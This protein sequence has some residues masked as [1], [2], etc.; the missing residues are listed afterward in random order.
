MSREHAQRHEAV[1]H[2]KPQVAKDEVEEKATKF[3]G[4]HPPAVAGA[5]H[6]Q[7]GTSQLA[8]EEDE[9]E[10]ELKQ[11]VGALVASQFGGDY[12]KAFSHFDSD[13]DGSVTK[14]ELVQ[15]LEEAG[16]GNGITR[17]MWAKKIIEKLDTSHDKGIQWA[18]FESVF[19]ARA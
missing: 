16:V 4:G 7:V 1:E 8:F 11:K 15:L 13:K 10:K 6:E 18:E 19:R 5:F 9:N 3:A 12:K 2:D 17:G 14:G